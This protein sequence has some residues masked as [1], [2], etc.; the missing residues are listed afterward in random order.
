MYFP[1]I[2]LRPCA[3]KETA[4]LSQTG[5]FC[6][7]TKTTSGETVTPEVLSQL[8][9]YFNPAV[10]R[11]AANYYDAADQYLGGNIQYVKLKLEA[12]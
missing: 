9:R 11:A 2:C 6:G 7:K 4:Q 1:Q 3:G 10:Y 8:R 5:I 12:R